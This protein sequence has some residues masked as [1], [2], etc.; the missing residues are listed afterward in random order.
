MSEVDPKKRKLTHDPHEIDEAE[1]VE[2]EVSSPL[3]TTKT[4]LK[5]NYLSLPNAL[6]V[7]KKGGDN[8]WKLILDVAY[9]K[10][11]TLAT[12][13]SFKVPPP[14]FDFEED[15]NGCMVVLSFEK[16][17]V[18]AAQ[19][20]AIM[21][22]NFVTQTLGNVY[23]VSSNDNY[24]ICGPSEV[25]QGK[26]RSPAH[27]F[28]QEL[29]VCYT[30]IVT[31]FCENIHLLP[32]KSIASFR[33]VITGL[34]L[35]L[36]ALIDVKRA[37][38]TWDTLK[39]LFTSPTLTAA[40]DVLLLKQKSST[41]ASAVYALLLEGSTDQQILDSLSIDTPKNERRLV[42][43]DCSRFFLPYQQK[44]SLLTAA[45]TLLK[46]VQIRD[47][48]AGQQ[49]ICENKPLTATQLSQVDPTA[50]VTL[51]ELGKAYRKVGKGKDKKDESLEE[52]R[53]LNLVDGAMMKKIVEM[54]SDKVLEVK[55]AS[56]VKDSAH[57][58]TLAAAAGDDE[59]FIMF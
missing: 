16:K 58:A 29:S 45:G 41:Y 19:F 59:D 28:K 4:W 52:W 48:V 39:A 42:L 27:V 22:R 1:R 2:K 17:V 50:F 3:D 26:Y 7:I 25:T 57:G 8:A 43:E 11:V 33:T 54:G 15:H 37:P 35:L 30:E 36:I 46:Q 13:L 18:S 14:G 34:N 38:A 23:V 21:I 12:M 31:L 53:N 49:V 6:E 24:I 9:C 44:D 56:K 20:K 47:L 32:I 5:Q 40:H 55:L 51:A 10:E